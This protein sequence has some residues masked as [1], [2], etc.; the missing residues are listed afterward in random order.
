LTN[1]IHSVTTFSS[2][3]IILLIHWMMLLIK[4][5]VM[6]TITIVFATTKI[7]FPKFIDEPNFS[8]CLGD[9]GESMV[10]SKKENAF[11]TQNRGTEYGFFMVVVVIG[12][13]LSIFFFFL[14]L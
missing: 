12:V 4:M 13:Y 9:F 5:V 8:V 11:T 6:I 3:L 1:D 14:C 7:H 10:F 2:R